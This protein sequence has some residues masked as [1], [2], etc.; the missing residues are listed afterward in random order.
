MRLV[1]VEQEHSN[2]LASEL[3]FPSCPTTPLYHICWLITAEG[4]LKRP[5]GSKG[6]TRPQGAKGPCHFMRWQRSKYSR[7]RKG[8]P[9]QNCLLPSQGPN[10]CH[11]R[12]DLSLCVYK[13]KEVTYYAL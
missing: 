3:F 4:E 8:D 5:K 9:I 12:L 2:A 6:S 13:S 11:P 7:G 10:Y 1:E